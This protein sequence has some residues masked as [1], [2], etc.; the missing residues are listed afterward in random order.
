MADQ[1]STDFES[2]GETLTASPAFPTI[3]A[4]KK[5]K[6]SKMFV[7]MQ[8][9]NFRL[10][11]NGAF[12]SNIGNWMQTIAQN[13]LVLSLSQSPFILGLV[14]F[15]GNLPMLLF[16][17]YGGVIADR[18][19]RRNVLLVTQSL[20]L[21]SILVMAILTFTNLINIWLIVIIV[22]FVGMV[23][24]FNAPAYQTIMLDLVGKE[25]LMNAIAMNSIQ[26][27]LS[28]VIGPAIAGVIVVIFGVAACFFINALSFGA[29]LLAL[30]MVQIPAI[31]T[32]TQKHTVTSE[33][34]E[35]FSFLWS[36]KPMLGLIASSAAFSIFVFP[37]LSLLSVFAKDVYRSG[38]DSYGL[39][40]GA[41]GVGAVI[42]GL[43][44][45][46]LSELEKR[47]RFVQIGTFIMVLSLV[48]FS[49]MPIILASLPFLAIA[50]GAMVTVQSSV[51]TIVQTNVPDNM[52]G[53][54]ISV[55]QL[56]SMGLLPIGSLL[57][58][59]AAEFI[60]APMTIA[61][62]VLIFGAITLAVFIFIPK[63]RYL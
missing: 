39:L 45:A 43:I 27:N 33:I 24:A 4:T 22:S 41:V 17:L 29:V 6:P 55:W 9:R 35:T 19:S 5:R 2:G 37:Y 31:T 59:T 38:A 20:M 25:N 7:A 23:S 57:G 48:I 61:V 34:R 18:N 14:N 16:G 11:W 10:F 12:V 53:R 13:W 46:R 28:R 47:A 62:G 58:G 51:N 36:N 21:I 52:R 40:M 49:F 50:G 42:G 44:I 54:I 30:F 3:P 56:A 60:G 32:T 26:F 1:P 15:I 63:T 8:N